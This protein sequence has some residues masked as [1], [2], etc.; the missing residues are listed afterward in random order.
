MIDADLAHSRVQTFLLVVVLNFLSQDYCLQ[1]L[2]SQFTN[3]FI[4]GQHLCKNPC[5]SGHV[6]GLFA[7][8]VADATFSL[9]PDVPSRSQ[10]CILPLKDELTDITK[11]SDTARR[12][13]QP[14]LA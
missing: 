14:A 7:R 10:F 4:V 12:A 5:W 2:L 13:A 1:K 11:W 9:L 3:L 8:P 6:P